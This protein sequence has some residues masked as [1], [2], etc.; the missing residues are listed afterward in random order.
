M[1]KG[2]LEL[3]GGVVDIEVESV[4]GR[5]GV[6]FSVRLER[7]LAFLLAAEVSIVSLTPRC[8]LSFV[9]RCVDICLRATC[10][11]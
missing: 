10:G 5:L 2:R 4:V 3:D 9:G 11:S 1:L 7:S 6:V 8:P